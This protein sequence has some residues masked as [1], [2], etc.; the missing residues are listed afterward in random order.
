MY[1]I[2]TLTIL[3]IIYF[4]YLHKQ[5]SKGVIPCYESE[6]KGMAWLFACTLILFMMMLGRL[7]YIQYH[8]THHPCEGCRFQPYVEIHY[9]PDGNKEEKGIIFKRCLNLPLYKF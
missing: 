5:E 1:T 8:G 4:V 6:H 3:T 2:P 9:N 7:A